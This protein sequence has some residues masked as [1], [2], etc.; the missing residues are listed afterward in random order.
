MRGPRRLKDRRAVAVVPPN[1][2]SQFRTCN[3]LTVDHRQTAVDGLG[4]RPRP[5]PY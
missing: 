5:L 2:G 1:A 3:K 4:G